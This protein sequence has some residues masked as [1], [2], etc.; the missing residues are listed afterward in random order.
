MQLKLPRPPR[1]FSS[2][3]APGRPPHRSDD[4]LWAGDDEEWEPGDRPPAER[5]AAFVGF[6]RAVALAGVVGIL[7][8]LGVVLLILRLT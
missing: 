1:F 6:F 7:F 2:G 5:P 3:A 4:D 8:W